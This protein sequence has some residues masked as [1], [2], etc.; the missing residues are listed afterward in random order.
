MAI[1]SP[2][3]QIEVQQII[4]VDAGVIDVFAR[5]E[6]GWLMP[7]V[8]VATGQ[9]VY[10]LPGVEVIA[11]PR[12][13]AEWRVQPEGRT[14]V[15]LSNLGEYLTGIDSEI[16]GGSIDGSDLDPQ[17]VA[18]RVREALAASQ[19]GRRM[20][21]EST[22]QHRESVLGQANRQMVRAGTELRLSEVDID[23]DE[24]TACL[25]M[26]GVR[27]GF[28]VSR[29]STSEV[30]Q[31]ADALAAIARASGFGYRW[32]RIDTDT[33][34]ANHVFLGFRTREGSESERDVE[35]VVVWSDGRGLEIQRAG[36]ESR[37]PVDSLADSGLLGVGVELFGLVAAEPVPR[38]RTLLRWACHGQ[39]RRLALV[40]AMA[41]LVTLTGLIGPVMTSAIVSTVVPLADVPLLVQAGGA[42][43]LAATLGGVF[44][45]V[46]VRGIADIAGRVSRRLA[47]AIWYRTLT[48]PVPV[49]R[50]FT[51][52]DLARRVS[53]VDA[54]VSL[55]S[56]AVV[57]AL[58]S[59]VFSIIY[60]GQM[61]V[62]APTL[63]VPAAVLLLLSGLILVW[64]LRRLAGLTRQSVER[65]RESTALLAQMLRGVAKL[66]VSGAE[67]IMQ[68]RYLDILRRITVSD[69]QQT[70]VMGR[71]AA[72]FAFLSGASTAVFIVIAGIQ[73]DS[74]GEPIPAAAFIAFTASFGLAI[75]AVSGLSAL[76]QPLS[77]STVAFE[78]IRPLLEAEPETSARLQDPGQLT[79]RIEFRDIH[80]RYTA[81]APLV[82]RGA[83]LAIEPG[84][85][86]AIVGTSGA[87]KS[88]LTRL[89]LAFDVPERGQIL[90]DGRDLSNLDPTLVR[91]QIGTVLQGAT[92]S[93]GSVLDNIVGT[94]SRDEERAW[95]AA[96]RAAVKADI[97]AMPMGMRTLVE[98]GNISG[99]QAQRIM[100]AR[101]LAFDPAVVI[102]DEATS[103]LDNAAQR[104][105]TESIRALGATR[106][107]IAHRLS[108]I[109][110]ADVIVA[111]DQGRVV[112]TGSFDDLLAVDG[113]VASLVR[114]QML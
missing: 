61:A 89:L 24:L 65:R 113:L 43:V 108:T 44:T 56:A 82:L 80:F 60:L 25:R 106:L 95:R 48:L 55:I 4:A 92:I 105:V 86:V 12:M 72:W 101:A 93:P 52:G 98:P 42:L 81:G 110:Q 107:V 2:Q 53:T 29:P 38:M 50:R 7:M 34:R 87:G 104:Q 8:T 13:D 111:L 51:S 16:G 41:L 66:R 6:D 64:A 71:V 70:L 85:M 18:F 47:P 83:E 102:L 103:A 58:L 68:A 27:T 67:P 62:I 15:E 94:N 30:H 22:I 76:L 35:P 57:V 79:G 36:E 45:I 109:R 10:P 114:R 88:T 28:E 32:L 1:E 77:F 21:R 63:T 5:R 54:F 3:R 112:E 84:Q 99:G 97:E 73:W 14:S 19:D 26:I 91:R 31:A 100:L 39:S 9:A 33:S 49:L 37:E 96:E 78:Q 74:T 40:A 90:V 75:A 23:D 20:V 59:A 69:G 17:G 46:Q 11:I